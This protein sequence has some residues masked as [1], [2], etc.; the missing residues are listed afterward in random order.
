[1]S[2]EINKDLLEE[3]KNGIESDEKRFCYVYPIF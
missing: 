1:M 3:I 2:N